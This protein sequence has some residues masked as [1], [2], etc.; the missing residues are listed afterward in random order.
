MSAML[1]IYDLATARSSILKHQPPDEMDVPE[2]LMQGIERRFGE[3]L[4]PEAAVR[5]VLLDIRKRGDEAVLEWTKRIE[6]FTPDSL[7]VDPQ[8]IATAHQRVPAEV[9]AALKFAAERIRRFHERQPAVSWLQSQPEGLLGQLVRPIERVGVYVPSGTAPLPSTLLM[10]AIPAQVAGVKEII[11]CTPQENDV[12]LQAAATIGIEE[13]YT[14]GGAVAVGAMAYGTPSL[15]RVDKIVGPGNIFVTI[16]KRMVYGVVGIDGLLGPTET[17]VIADEHSDPELAA[18]DLLAQ[19]E[20]DVLASAILLTPSRR[21][22]EKVQAA[23]ERQVQKLERAEIIRASMSN[24]GGIVLVEDLP[25]AF[26]LANDYAPEHLCI[27][28]KDAYQWIGYVKHAGGIFLGEQSYEVLGDYVAGPSHSM[29]TGGS[30]RFASPLNV[31][32]FVKIVSLVGLTDSA[33]RELSRQAAVL[34]HAEHLTAH[35]AAAQA[36]FKEPAP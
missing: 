35:A 32:D 21:F 9:C 29:P 3:R 16:A 5:R 22:A 6:G 27:L 4:T 19:A 15:P 34:A 10:S 12:I 11:V 17:L 30:A 14:L 26:E 24:N 36:R 23:V 13:I 2:S 7:T 28:L 25:Q 20:H 18:A 8:K 33:S 1:P 31:L